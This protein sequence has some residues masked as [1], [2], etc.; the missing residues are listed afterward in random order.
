[1]DAVR[2]VEGSGATRSTAAG[3][4]I[5]ATLEMGYQDPT[6]GYVE[7]HTHMTAGG[8]HASLAAQSSESEKAL[9][10]HL[11]SLADWMNDRQTPV[12]SLTVL[13]SSSDRHQEAGRHDGTTSMG[14]GG[15]E[16]RRGSGTLM[17]E[18]AGGGRNGSGQSY[19]D[20]ESGNGKG[21][22]HSIAVGN[23]AIVSSQAG[24]QTVERLAP[25]EIGSGE[26]GSIVRAADH[27]LPAKFDEGTTG[28]T[29][30]VLV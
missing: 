18:G 27:G 21:A 1:M 24:N 30:S 23:H 13:S 28:S 16:S 4:Q 19:G 15:G 11:H 8:V 6:L 29:I 2:D 5:L 20:A 14:W 22:M 25:G 17:G 10:S 3:S 9:E 7:L 12:E 26:T